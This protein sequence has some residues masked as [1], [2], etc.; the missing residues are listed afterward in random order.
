MSGVWLVMIH[1]GIQFGSNVV[2]KIILAASTIPFGTA[3]DLVAT[4]WRTP[5]AAMLVGGVVF[6]WRPLRARLGALAP[7]AGPRTQIFA[8]IVV[9]GLA[10]VSALHVPAGQ[11]T[12]INRYGF[13]CSFPPSNTAQIG[14]IPP[15]IPDQT[16]VTNSLGYRDEEWSI[17]AE[18]GVRRVLL[19]GDS[20]VFGYGIPTQEGTLDRALQLELNRIDD[21]SWEVINIA[22][23]PAALWYYIEGLL[24]VDADARADV[25]VMSFLGGYDLEPSEIQRVAYG[26][27][28]AMMRMLEEFDVLGDLMRQQARVG[29]EYGDTPPPEILAQYRTQL[30]RLIEHLE[31]Q[32]SHLIVW[33]HYNPSPLFDQLRDHPSISLMNWGQD[34]PEVGPSRSWSDD[35]TLAIEGDGHPTPKANRLIARALAAKIIASTGRSPPPSP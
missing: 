27:S 10:L 2:L 25:M 1:L 26:H 35:K 29:S 31:A 34:V 8:A 28:E 21:R 3:I 13:Y 15:H 6:G 4:S 32:D 24:V 7:K 22:M 12:R 23:T 14:G 30:S 11:S 5:L 19:T 16:I 33:E 17:E 9:I 20:F 18:P